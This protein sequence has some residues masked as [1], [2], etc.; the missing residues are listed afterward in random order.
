MRLS[1]SQIF[2]SGLSALQRAQSNLNHTNLQM[3]TGQRI[4]TPSDDPSGATV[5]VQLSAAINATEQYQRNVDLAQPRL[6]QEEAQLNSYENYLQRARE[7]IVLG[8]NDSYNQADRM[9]FASEIRQLREGILGLANSKDSNG[10]YLF[11]GTE[12]FVQ[13]FAVDGDGQVSYVGADGEGSVRNVAISGTRSIQVG[14]TGKS[15]FM[16][17]PEES[18]KLIEAL[19]AED[20]TGSL[21]VTETAVTDYDE[22]VKSVDYGPGFDGPN[23]DRTFN[24]EFKLNTVT[25]DMEYTVFDAASSSVVLDKS[26]QPIQDVVFDPAL[27]FPIQFAGRSVTLS[28]VPEDGDTVTSRPARYVSIFETLDSIATAFEAPLATDSAGRETL[29]RAVDIAFNNI[30]SSLE[31]MNEVRTSAGLRL[32]AIDVQT[33]L[34]SQRKLD[35][36]STLSDV[37]DL[38]YAEAISRFKMEQVVLEAAQQTYTQVTKMSLF[39]YM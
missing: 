7:L 36:N 9:T 4:L 31:R 20:N 15:I 25:N 29:S 27:P 23:S 28:G 38:D 33:D 1:T 35:L 12:S 17:I 13:P 32:N 6:E 10:E 5:S 8:N 2:Q 3:A 30:D 16:N 11:S 14:D 22:Y 21:V 26:D 24:I 19:P 34:N 39:D 37:R 18:G